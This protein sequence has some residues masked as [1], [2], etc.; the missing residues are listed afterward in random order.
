MSNLQNV[1][2]MEKTLQQQVHQKTWFQRFKSNAKY[3][4]I[5]LSLY[6][7]TSA[8][9]APPAIELTDI[10]AFIVIIVAAVATVGAAMMMVTLTAKAFKAVKAAF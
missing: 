7:A 5:P 2:V 10:L 1:E 4:V 3:S 6:A 8:H 9:A